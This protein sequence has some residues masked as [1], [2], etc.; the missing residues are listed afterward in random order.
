MSNLQLDVP[1]NKICDFCI[2]QLVNVLYD[3][4][5]SHDS[6][7]QANA[8]TVSTLASS[9]VGQCT[10]TQRLLKPLRE[11]IVDKP[12]YISGT[13]NLPESNFSLVYKISKDDD[14]RSGE[15]LNSQS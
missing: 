5:P 3:V 8:S 10:R 9:M 7:E 6:L 14:A 15:T 2:G 12:P 1:I 13:L 11:S 4:N